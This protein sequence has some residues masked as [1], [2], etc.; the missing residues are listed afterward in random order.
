MSKLVRIADYQRKQSFVYFNRIEMN[1]LLGLYA[2]RVS[3]G[4]WRDYAIDHGPGLARFS[5]FRTDH[6]RALFVVSKRVEDNQVNY[7]VAS[8]ERVLRNAPVL[9]EALAML[10]RIPRLVCPDGTP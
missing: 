4:F 8:G 5:V 7:A 3:D 9:S 10:E 1:L 6:E 2:R